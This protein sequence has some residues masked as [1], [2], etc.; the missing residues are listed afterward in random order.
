[1]ISVGA[2]DAG[3]LVRALNQVEVPA[4][5]IG[6]VLAKRKPVIEIVI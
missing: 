5:Q 1:L 3:R 4:V 2:D 6:E